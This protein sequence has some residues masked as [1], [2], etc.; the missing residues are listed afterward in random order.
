MDEIEY[1]NFL[2]DEVRR[3]LERQYNLSGSEEWMTDEKFDLLSIK[4][5]SSVIHTAVNQLEKSNKLRR[6][7]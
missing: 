5:L 3:L 2:A 1:T 7:R 6:K 4:A